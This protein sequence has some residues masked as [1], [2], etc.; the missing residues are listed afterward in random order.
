MAFYYRSIVGVVSVT[1]V[2]RHAAA[3]CGVTRNFIPAAVVTTFVCYRYR[4]W[5]P[6]RL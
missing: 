3:G 1:A 2:V 4:Y 5:S 6:F